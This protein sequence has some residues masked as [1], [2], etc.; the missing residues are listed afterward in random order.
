MKKGKER[1]FDWGGVGGSMIPL[2]W[3]RS[4]WGI[5]KILIE[6]NEVTKKNISPPIYI[7]D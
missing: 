5:L 7:I 3:G 1:R 4:S 2:F 6:I